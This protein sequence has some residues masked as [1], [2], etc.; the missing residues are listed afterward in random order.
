MS[1][2]DPAILCH[3]EPSARDLLLIDPTA[4]ITGVF[5]AALGFAR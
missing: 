2:A 5:L 3:P 1:R 4:A